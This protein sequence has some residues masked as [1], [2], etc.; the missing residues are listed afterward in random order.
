MRATI[1]IVLAFAT[2][3]VVATSRNRN[4]SHFVKH[5]ARPR[6]IR[7]FKP[8]YM[9]TAYGFGKRQSIIDVPKINRQERILFT[10]LRYFPQRYIYILLNYSYI[11]SNCE[12]LIYA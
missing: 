10:F 5:P 3:I 11:H 6:V 4:Y 12:D 8:E 7:G 9:S 1:I 2:G